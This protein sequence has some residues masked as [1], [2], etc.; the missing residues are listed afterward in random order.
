LPLGAISLS[1]VLAA[2]QVG[3]ALALRSRR[4]AFNGVGLVAAV[5][6]AVATASVAVQGSN[7]VGG[8]ALADVFSNFVT[9]LFYVAITVLAAQQLVSRL[10]HSRPRRG[11]AA[12]T[13]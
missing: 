6:G 8:Y 3:I 9:S 4:V 12:R 7:S 5:M 11:G 2:I 10:T 13:A 1:V